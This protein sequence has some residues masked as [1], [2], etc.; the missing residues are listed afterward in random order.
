MK[1]KRIYDDNTTSATTGEYLSCRG[2]GMIPTLNFLKTIGRVST[3]SVD[4]EW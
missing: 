4:S 2:K 1:E 3:K